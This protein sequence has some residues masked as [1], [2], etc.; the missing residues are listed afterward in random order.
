MS[1]AVATRQ[2]ASN[3]PVGRRDAETKRG[4]APGNAPPVELAPP[5]ELLIL[6]KASC[7]CGGGG[8][9]RARDSRI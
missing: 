5:G 2:V 3:A 4:L 1:R 7:A 8:T 6:R 9:T